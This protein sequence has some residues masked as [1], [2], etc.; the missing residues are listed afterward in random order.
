MVILAGC[1]S[2]ASPSPSS[3][4]SGAP[5]QSAAPATPSSSDAAVTILVPT[6]NVERYDPF[7]MG[8]SAPYGLAV[9]ATLVDAD[10]NGNLVPGIASDWS[11]SDDGLTWTG[12]SR[13]A[14]T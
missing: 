7:G 13:S 4:Q 10:E 14:T 2:A 8:G 1:N 6:F 11:L 3:G 5:G 9:H 12:R